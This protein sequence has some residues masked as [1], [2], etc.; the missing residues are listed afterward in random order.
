MSPHSKAF[1]PTMK[2]NYEKKLFIAR[3][4]LALALLVGVLSAFQD[5]ELGDSD[6]DFFGKN[7]KRSYGTLASATAIGLLQE[8]VDLD[9]PFSHFFVTEYSTLIF[10]L[11]IA[12]SL[13]LL[14]FLLTPILLS[15][16]LSVS[17]I[18]SFL[19]MLSHVSWHALLIY[20][21]QKNV[22]YIYLGS[23]GGQF[24][25]QPHISW[26]SGFYFGCA[27]VILHL[28]GMMVLYFSSPP[29]LAPP[30]EA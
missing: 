17:R 28:L 7:T 27:A 10:I 1:F 25:F 30:I 19:W 29:K 20:T 6:F 24:G 9:T 26:L 14:L 4:I 2:T 16:Q 15:R 18:L 13:S 22:A 11:R 23:I 8:C 12:I 3:V 21:Y 5:W